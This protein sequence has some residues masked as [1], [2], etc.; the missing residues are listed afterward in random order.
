MPC[1]SP[2]K[3]RLMRSFTRVEPSS[4]IRT[5]PWK[6]AIRQLWEKTGVLRAKRQTRNSSFRLASRI[7]ELHRHRLAVGCGHLETL[8]L[9]EAEHSGEDVRRKR[10]D[11]G[12]QVA[13]DGIVV[14]P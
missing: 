5:V 11:L 12:I 4:V 14:T 6:S 13:D 1:H 9:L 3:T 10:L 8:F 2:M 7:L